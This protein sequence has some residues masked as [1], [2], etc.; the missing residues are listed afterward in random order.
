MTFSQTSGNHL[1]VIIKKAAAIVNARNK[2]LEPR[3]SK[4]IIK[5]AEEIIKG[6]HDNIFL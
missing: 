5:A 2:D 1:S 4:F 3:I 6:K